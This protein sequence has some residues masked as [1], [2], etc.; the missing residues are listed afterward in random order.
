MSGGRSIPVVAFVGRSGAGKTTLLCSVV[1]ILAARGIRVAAIK[2]AHHGF[3]IDHP[4]KDSMRLREAGANPVLVL[5]PTRKAWVEEVAP[6]AEPDLTETLSLFD[7][8]RIDLV[9][10]EGFRGEGVPKIELFAPELGPRFCQ[11]DPDLLAVAAVGALP[12]SN[13]LV[14]FDRN[15][16]EGV[17]DLILRTCGLAAPSP[18]PPSPPGTK[19][20]LSLAEA[21]AILR[22]ELTPVR[23]EGWEEV[24]LAESV[25]RILAIDLASPV[26][27][28]TAPTAAMDGYA[29]RAASLGERPREFRV[30]GSAAAGA[31]FSGALSKGWCVR[32]FTG[33]ILPEG[34]DLVIPQEEVSFAGA[35]VLL[36]GGRSAG[37]N[38]RLQ[39]ENFRQGQKLLA[40]GT[41]IGPRTLAL[42]ASIGG[43]RVPVRSRLRVGLLCT[44]KELRAVGEPL[45]LGEVYDSNRVFLS[46]GLLELG[47]ELIDAGIVDDDPKLLEEKLDLLAEEA[48]LLVTTGGVS[49]GE[50]DYVG[51]LLSER[52]EVVFRQIA[53]KPG[54]PFLFAR[55]GGKPLFGLPGTPSAV[56]V[57]FYDL[58]GPAIRRCMGEAAGTERTRLPSLSA[59]RK[60]AGRTEYYAGRLVAGP[61]GEPAF[62]PV[63]L[64]DGA[65]LLPAAWA[66]LLALL[67]EESELVEAGER[68]EVVFLPR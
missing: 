44:G 68:I 23:P 45:R 2:H 9:L 28:P 14:T 40:A 47:V 66:D 67:P 13:G 64:V 3:E 56:F 27:L 15:D 49:V 42:L 34:T 59:I 24:V 16:A 54:R 38:V 22:E 11:E 10:V 58:I 55:W 25:G 39:G 43:K 17:A 30:A 60:R 65:G 26:D 41:K 20:R 36:P 1:R 46:A 29:V 50:G 52:S 12:P 21:R 35:N 19:G 33:A 63:S 62:A 48:D 37:E 31:P 5:S 53:V 57:L 18:V 4:G 8:S 32:I 51:K 61:A 6:P 7:R